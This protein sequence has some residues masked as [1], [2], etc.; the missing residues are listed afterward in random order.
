MQR[1]DGALVFLMFIQCAKMRPVE[2]THI[3]YSACLIAFWTVN[4]K[5]KHV[6]KTNSEEVKTSV[7]TQE[8][9]QRMILFF[10]VS[11]KH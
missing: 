10:S 4:P 7:D 8:H 6:I 5:A 9:P 1:A 3:L 2:H 11:L